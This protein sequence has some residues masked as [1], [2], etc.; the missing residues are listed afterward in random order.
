M[1]MAAIFNEMEVAIQT[2]VPDVLN[3]VRF[4]PGPYNGRLRD[5]DHKADDHYLATRI[6]QIEE[7][8]GLD[9][10]T[11]NATLAQFV[12][13][14]RIEI[15]YIWNKDNGGW[16]AIRD[17][18]ACDKDRIIQQL[19][20][21]AWSKTTTAKQLRFVRDVRTSK[22]AREHYLDIVV[23]IQYHLGPQSS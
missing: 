13:F 8:E 12:H 1:T 14:A 17:M 16:R 19:R 7:H 11:M 2:I 23:A 5:L 6:F 22:S 15:Q 10:S 18:M 21:W 20:P 3:A 9:D 4:R